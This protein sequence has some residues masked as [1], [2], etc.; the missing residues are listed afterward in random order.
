MKNAFRISCRFSNYRFSFNSRSCYL[1]SLFVVWGCGFWLLGYSDF[2]LAAI[3][4]GLTGQDAINNMRNI[5]GSPVSFVENLRDD[6][7]DFIQD[8]FGTMAIAAAFSLGLRAF[9]K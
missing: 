6:T 9:V 2:V 8:H 1:A 7:Q 4:S 3:P 5:L